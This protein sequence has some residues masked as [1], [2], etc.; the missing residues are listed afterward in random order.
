MPR[1]NNLWPEIYP[2]SSRKVEFIQTALQKTFGRS[3]LFGTQFTLNFLG[4]W[5]DIVG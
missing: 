5:L 3:V 2:K 4:E 1:Y